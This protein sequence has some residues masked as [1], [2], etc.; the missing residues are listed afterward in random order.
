M[1][2]PVRYPLRFAC[3]RALRD[4]ALRLREGDVYARRM[5]HWVTVERADGSVWEGVIGI[6]LPDG[7]VEE[8]SYGGAL[9][10]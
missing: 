6:D 7:V 10:E 8:V 4:C 5:E 3:A 1:S 9:D 2:E